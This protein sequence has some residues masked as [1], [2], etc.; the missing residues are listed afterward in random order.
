MTDEPVRGTPSWS[1]GGA[2][3]QSESCHVT[4]DRC[5]HRFFA[6]AVSPNLGAPTPTASTA[7][8]QRLG[9]GWVNFEGNLS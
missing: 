9:G 4:P 2:R 5:Q 6:S 8:Q 1:H 7:P 3:H